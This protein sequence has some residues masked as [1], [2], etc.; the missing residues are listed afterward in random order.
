LCAFAVA[1]EIESS[2]S[3]YGATGIGDSLP[4]NN[5]S[6]QSSGILDTGCWQWDLNYREAALYLKVVCLNVLYC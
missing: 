6:I 2:A 4:Q 3:S 1:E 5:N